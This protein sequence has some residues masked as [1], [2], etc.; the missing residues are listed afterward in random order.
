M[1]A[2]GEILVFHR[3]GRGNCRT[4]LQT[5]GGCRRVCSRRDS[6][7]PFIGSHVRSACK[8][9]RVSKIVMTTPPGKDEKINPAILVAANEPG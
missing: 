9:G 3:K 4:A 1:K 5:F 7:L 6:G 2:E 8:G